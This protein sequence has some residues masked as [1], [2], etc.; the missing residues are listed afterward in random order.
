VIGMGALDAHMG[1]VGGQIEA[2][3]LSKVMGTSTCDM[4]VAFPVE[5]QEKL[6]EGICGQVRDSIIPGMIGMEA[7]QS[8]FGDIYAWFAD[9]ISWPS[10]KILGR[11]KIIDEVTAYKLA[12]EIKE[13]ILI[14]LAKAAS[15]LPLEVNSEL[16]V[17]WLN[18][19]RTPNAN[20]NLKGAILG[21]NLGSDA[22]LIYRS[23]VEST[24][25]GS[26]RIV[27]HF[28]S[29]GIN[30]KGVIGVGGVAK[31]APFIMQMM[32]D[33]LGMPIKIHK[34]EQTCALGAS[35]FAATVAGTYS[36]VEEAMV[37]M[38]PG[39]EKKYYPNLERSRIY[40]NRYEKYKNFSRFLES[41]TSY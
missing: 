31:K 19:R 16:A 4:I 11:S 38:G 14:E 22:P 13:N 1:A 41:E 34:S 21:L 12:E 28:Q 20:Q 30:I 25:F 29:G 10:I 37:S 36:R 24:C 7:G 17:D 6:V 3:F 26:K 35:M 33:V 2:N 40:N 32:A 9:M 18:G 8:A 39:F 15:D 5:M 27:E 23:L